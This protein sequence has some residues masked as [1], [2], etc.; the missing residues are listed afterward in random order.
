MTATATLTPHKI[1]AILK[2]LGLTQHRAASLLGVSFVSI[3]R[4]SLG[5]GTP[6]RYNAAMLHLLAG[7]LDT[8]PPGAVLA[9]LHDAAGEPVAI[10]QTLVRL[11]GQSTP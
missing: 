10:L 9:E 3:S 8:T 4:W 2:K 7:A 11:Q 1:K 5:K 6:D